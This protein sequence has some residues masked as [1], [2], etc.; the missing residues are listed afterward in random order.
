MLFTLPPVAILFMI[1][2][3]GIPIGLGLLALY[4][5]LLLLGY[6]ATA[7][8]IGREAANAMHQPKDVTLGKQIAFLAGALLLL[9]IVAM[10][11]VLGGLLM[12]LALV[13]GIGG[14]AVWLY[15]RYRGEAP[16]DTDAAAGV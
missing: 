2:V 14:W 7:F 4:P 15:Q 16:R 1:T 13:I 5:V 8:F 6:L 12:F 10:I 11:P 9:T 3:I